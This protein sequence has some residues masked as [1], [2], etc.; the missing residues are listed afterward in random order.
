MSDP[1]AQSLIAQY[2]IHNLLK[3]YS[4]KDVVAIWFTG[5]PLQGNEH[6]RDANGTRAGD[7]VEQVLALKKR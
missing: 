7:Y 5:Q 1:K 4:E 6:L 2:K 3:R